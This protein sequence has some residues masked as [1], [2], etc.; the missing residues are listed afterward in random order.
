MK[1]R[2]NW[3]HR[4]AHIWA[5][6]DPEHT[7]WICRKC[8]QPIL[9]G[10]PWDLGHLLDQATHGP[11]T[12]D[13]QPEHSG[14]CNRA[15]GGRLRHQRRAQIP[16]SRN[17][18]NPTPT[19]QPRRVILLC[20]P[21]GAGK[22]TIANQLAQQGL[23]IYDRDHPQWAGNEATFKKA[24]AQI[25]TNPNAHAVV[26]RAGATRTARDQAAQLIQATETRIIATPL[27]QCEQRILARS[28]NSNPAG[29]LTAAR[30][31]WRDYQA[32]QTT[33]PATLTPSRRW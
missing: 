8:N 15:A 11:N 25:A 32:E 12:I 22:S 24:I 2:A 16:P 19:N 6:T 9:P 31:W 17:W 5:G 21:P 1:T 29:E 33:Q 30:K 20:G 10:Q 4:L 28:R 14:R 7:Q 13:L 3:T 23:T 26:I 18:T 27:N